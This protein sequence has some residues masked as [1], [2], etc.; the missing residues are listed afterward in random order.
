MIEPENVALAP[1]KRYTAYTGMS[2]LEIG[3]V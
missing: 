3:S 1:A 2:S